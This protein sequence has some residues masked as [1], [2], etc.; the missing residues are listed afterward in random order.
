MVEYK[1][2]A[3]LL[4]TNHALRPYINM[5]LTVLCW[6]LGKS[7]MRM[8][9]ARS[10]SDM[11]KVGDWPKNM[12]HRLVWGRKKK[13]KNNDIDNLAGSE[14]DIT[15]W[16]HMV[17]S[18]GDITWWCHMVISHGDK[19]DITYFKGSFCDPVIPLHKSWYFW[20]Q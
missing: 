20:Y 13:S 11:I 15:W 1:K 7:L 3:L 4:L 17:M 6:K 18:H 10:G 14:R 19:N 12:L 9:L 16:C 8:C 2:D 5:Q